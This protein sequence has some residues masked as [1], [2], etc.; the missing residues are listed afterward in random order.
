MKVN[1]ETK[2]YENV[3]KSLPIIACLVDTESS[4]VINTNELFD[5]RLGHVVCKLQNG[6]VSCDAL[7][8]NSDR[9]SFF[10][11]LSTSADSCTIQQFTTILPTSKSLVSFVSSSVYLFCSKTILRRQLSGR[12]IQSQVLVPTLFFS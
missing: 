7:V 4:I 2:F 12:L 8:N 11:T 10:E 1:E 3:F 6:E 9:I 5:T